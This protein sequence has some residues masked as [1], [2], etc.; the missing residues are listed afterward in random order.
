MLVLDIKKAFDSVSHSILLRKLEHYGIRGIAHSLLKTYL[1]KRKQYVSIAAH[2]STDRTIEF[3]ASQ[4]SILEPVL[5]LIFINNLA[6]CLQTIPD[7]MQLTLHCT[8]LENRCL[9]MCKRYN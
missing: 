3:G 4:E 1:E 7:F 8:F 5:F 6:L 9:L 2:N